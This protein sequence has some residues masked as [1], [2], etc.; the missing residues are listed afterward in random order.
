MFAM[1]KIFEMKRT[2]MICLIAG[3]LTGGMGARSYAA[4]VVD[5]QF[6]EENAEISVPE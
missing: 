3:M 4:E 2:I 1:R 5:T 6:E